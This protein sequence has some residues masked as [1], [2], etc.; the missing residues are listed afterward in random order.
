MKGEGRI[1]QRPGRP[2]WMLD[3]YGEVNG[4][5]VRLRE[6]SG[7]TDEEKE[8]LRVDRGAPGRPA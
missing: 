4:R 7:T 5:R 6:S 3:Y 8:G 2:V 1:Y